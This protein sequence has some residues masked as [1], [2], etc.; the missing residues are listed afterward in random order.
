MPDSPATPD[1]ASSAATAWRMCSSRAKA[2]GCAVAPVPPGSDPLSG[3]FDV[4][5]IRPPLC[6]EAGET[7]NPGRS[8]EVVEWLFGA[9]GQDLRPFGRVGLRPSDANSR[10][11]P[12]CIAPVRFRS[13]LHQ[14]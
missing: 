3:L 10:L 14:D 8:A 1:A 5:S 6:L 11:P 7:K 9:P 12:N 2:G 4:P 13:R